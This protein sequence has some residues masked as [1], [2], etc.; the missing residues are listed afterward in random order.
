MSV[1]L[2]ISDI[3]S[4]IGQNKFD[5]TKAFERL[6]KKADKKNLETIYNSINEEISQIDKQIGELR[7]KRET[8]QLLSHIEKLTSAKEHLQ[9][10]IDQFCFSQEYFLKKEFGDII[11]KIEKEDLSVEEKKKK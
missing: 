5:P 8:R 3:A 11:T 7:T 1:F 2:F 10:S 6:W 9:L 4:Y